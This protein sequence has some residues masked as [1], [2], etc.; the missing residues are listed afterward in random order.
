MLVPGGRADGRTGGPADRAVRGRTRPQRSRGRAAPAAP[1]ERR[2]PARAGSGGR[3]GRGPLPP[4]LDRGR[5]AV[6]RRP[7]HR[8]PGAPARDAST[9][10]PP[11]WTPAA[12]A[13]SGAVAAPQRARARAIRSAGFVCV[14][15][16]P[17]ATEDETG[18]PFV[19]R[20]GK[21]LEDILKAIGFTR[22]DVFIC[23]VLKC[24]PPEQPRPRAA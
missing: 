17:G 10:S 21:L 19:G 24:R 22:E 12:S 5:A 7:L 2:A 23:N 4:G 14:G 11:W 13:R 6:G 9:P 1:A 18:R 16:A 8:G 20:A 3:A 15:E